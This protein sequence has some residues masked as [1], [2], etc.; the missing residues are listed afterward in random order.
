[1]SDAARDSDADETD[2]ELERLFRESETKAAALRGLEEK[3]QRAPV[4]AMTLALLPEECV[5]AVL[6]QCTARA[7]TNAAQTCKRF[8]QI[9]KQALR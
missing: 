8:R 6:K 5:V 2:D 4:N 1:M 9:A 3:P 7:V